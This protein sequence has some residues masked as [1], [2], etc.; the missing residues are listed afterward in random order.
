MSVYARIENGLVAE[1]IQ[2]LFKDDGT[3][4]PIE[5][6]FTAE[7][8]ATLVDITGMDPQPLGGWVATNTGGIWTFA[9]YIAPGQP[10]PEL[11]ENKRVVLRD[12]CSNEI[13][14]SSF[15]SNA[16]G[17]VHNYDCRIVDQLNLKVRFDIAASTGLDEPLWASDGTRYQWKDHSSE[18]IMEVMIDM[19]EHVKLA[20][21]KLASKLAAVDA[22]TTPAQI[23]AIVW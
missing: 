17:D 2:P 3:E 13:T 9:P 8:V 14:R 10:L 15:Q 20:Q 11:A 1:I 4:W 12:A 5:A 7:F 6:R 23:E 19:N 21:V 22:A 16:L 18:E